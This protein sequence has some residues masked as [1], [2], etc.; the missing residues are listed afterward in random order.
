MRW[1]ADE[2]EAD[3]EKR[4]VAARQRLRAEQVEAELF[5]LQAEAAKARLAMEEEI[6]LAKLAKVCF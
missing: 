1:L 2:A 3:A 5:A 4:L 6:E